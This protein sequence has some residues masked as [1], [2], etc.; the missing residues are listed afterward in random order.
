L[1]PLAAVYQR[2]ARAAA[3]VAEA[4]LRQHGKA[5]FERQFVLKRIADLMIDLFVGLCVISR[6]NSLVA[7]D[8]ASKAELVQVAEIFTQQARRRMVRNIR[9]EAHNEDA[10]VESLAQAVLQHGGYR[11]DVI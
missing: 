9:G 8:P 5:I 7:S 4:A 10:A 3:R 2:Y 6:A 11:W 1:R